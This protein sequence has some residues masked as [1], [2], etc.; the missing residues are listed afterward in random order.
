MSKLG[1]SH[2]QLHEVFD[3]IAAFNQMKPRWGRDPVRCTGA[4]HNIQQNAA[5]I[6]A[7]QVSGDY[8]IGRVHSTRI[9]TTPRSQ[10]L[11]TIR[12]PSSTA[13]SFALQVR[14]QAAVTASGTT[15][16]AAVI[17]RSE[18][19]STLT[20]RD[21]PTLFLVF[22]LVDLAACKPFSEDF[23]WREACGTAS[24]GRCSPVSD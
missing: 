6:K 13:N 22:G 24:L 7:L 17:R 4:A 21:D 16:P 2:N 20:L 12:G 8:W 11:S 5:T 23:E 14:P 10:R 19:S 1:A 18:A 3:D 15:F 9:A